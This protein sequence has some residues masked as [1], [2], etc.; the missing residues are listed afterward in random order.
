MAVYLGNQG[1][2][3]RIEGGGKNGDLFRM[4]FNNP[5]LKNAQFPTESEP[6]Y[7]YLAAD[8]FSTNPKFI[9]NM[10]MAID[11]SSDFAN[12]PERER[13]GVV[14]LAFTSPA[15]QHDI[16]PK[17]LEE[18]LKTGKPVGPIPADARDVAF[19]QENGL[20]TRHTEHIHNYFTTVRWQLSDTGQWVTISDKGRIT[21]FQDP[22]VRALA[23]KYGNPDDIFSYDWIP[24]IP[25]IN[26]PGD[27][28]KDYGTDPWKWISA[29]WHQMVA[30]TYK[31]LVR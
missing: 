5:T 25:G 17:E 13:A 16:D 15:A 8:G 19:A 28:M 26:V 4:L 23:S 12:L 11:G 21:A 14:H 20:P 29:E 3:E 6:G 24:A 2:V 27:Y 30:G 7:W 1:R 31:Y 9:R 22:E 10:P 18:G